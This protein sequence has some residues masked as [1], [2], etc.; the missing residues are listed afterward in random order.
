MYSILMVTTVLLTCSINS[1]DRCA[2][3][4]PGPWSSPPDWRSPANPGMA[5]CST[6]LNPSRCSQRVMSQMWL[7]AG[8]LDGPSRLPMHGKNEEAEVL[9]KTNRGPAARPVT[10]VPK[11]VALMKT[12]FASGA[13]KSRVIDRPGRSIYPFAEYLLVRVSEISSPCQRALPM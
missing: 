8:C 9:G 2:A 6:G 13:G 7:W 11:R 3:V 4:D 5:R 1:I 12:K 10:A